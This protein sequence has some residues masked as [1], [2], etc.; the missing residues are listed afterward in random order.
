MADPRW[1]RTQPTSELDECVE[2]DEVPVDDMDIHVQDLRRCY[3]SMGPET[4]SGRL[5]SQPGHFD[6]GVG[7]D[8]FPSSICQDFKQLSVGDHRVSNLTILSETSSDVCDSGWSEE[9]LHS[10]KC[11]IV[12]TDNN[13][14]YTRPSEVAFFEQDEDGD[15]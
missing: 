14:E 10:A 15:T 8:S 7:L 13:A 1:P 11:P 3:T 12:E 4:D 9:R 2:T 5:L 6:S